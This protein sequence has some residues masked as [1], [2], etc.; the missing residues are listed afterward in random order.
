MDFDD[1]VR[2]LSRFQGQAVLVQLRA[3]HGG[4]RFLELLDRINEVWSDTDASDAVYINFG[5]AEAG[6]TLRRSHF[7]EADWEPGWRRGEEGERLLRVRLGEV[8]V[9][10]LAG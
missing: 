10:F 8:D 6:L 3:V 7:I 2:E 4:F 9:G 5:D 1:A